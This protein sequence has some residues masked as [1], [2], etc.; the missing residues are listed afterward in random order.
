MRKFIFLVFLQSFDIINI[1]RDFSVK[2][3]GILTS[4]GD[5]PGL[6][7]VIRGIC[8]A[9]IRKYKIKVIGILDGYVGFE[10]GRCIE[11]TEKNID[12][13]LKKGGT[14]LGSTREKPFKN[15]EKIE[16]TGLNAVDSIKK[17][18]KKWKLDAVAVLGGN[19]TNTTAGLLA[20]EGL[21]VIG[22]PKTIDND[23]AHTDYTFGFHTAMG[24]ATEALDRICT[25]AW[26]HHRVMVVEI[27]GH[28][29]GWLGLYSG[30]AGGADVILLPEIPYDIKKV[31]KKVKE[32]KA[33]GKGYSIVVVAEGA[34]TTKEAELDKKAY[35]KARETMGMSIG[36]RVAK[37]IEAETGFETRASVLGHMQRGGSPCAY[38]RAL[39]SMFGT[40]AVEHIVKGNF[41]KILVMQNNKVVDIPL[42]DV[43]G[44]VKNVPQ[45]DPMIESG[46]ALGICFGD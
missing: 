38:D 24:V 33:S 45:N 4:G 19:G 30:I 29:A 23:I 12:D 35:K 16:A 28:K 36:A 42:E 2:T 20:K 6:N 39:C 21:N 10:Q 1:M 41:G 43:A 8:L 18:Y 46:R 32:V 25:T 3:I 34:L 31:A 44:L 5:A 14:L 13:I 40:M 26:S 27:M 9:A 37:E 11:L 15:K 22:L 17:N 7:A